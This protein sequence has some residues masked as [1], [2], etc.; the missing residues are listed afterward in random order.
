MYEKVNNITF[1]MRK[2]H[3]RIA[4]IWMLVYSEN[5][6][7]QYREP[8]TIILHTTSA[9][10]QKMLSEWEQANFEYIK[11]TIQKY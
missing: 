9:S 10:G 7:Y 2:L 8:Y 6:I 3:L 4:V 5:W 1:H 11:W